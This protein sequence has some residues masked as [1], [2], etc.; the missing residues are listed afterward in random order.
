MRH[1][2]E[3]VDREIY[4][5]FENEARQRLLG[6]DES[7]WPGGGDAGGGPFL[8]PWTARGSPIL[9]SAPSSS[10]DFV[11]LSNVNSDIR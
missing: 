11:V 9:P 7:D 1:I 8:Q 2:I 10:G 4:G 6:R 3:P 5:L